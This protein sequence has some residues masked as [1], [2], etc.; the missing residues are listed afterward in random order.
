MNFLNQV[1]GLEMLHWTSN[2]IQYDGAVPM[3]PIVPFDADAGK[4]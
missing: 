1:P 4:Q 2:E 3:I